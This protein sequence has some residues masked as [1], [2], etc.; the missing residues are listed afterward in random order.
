MTLETGHPKDDNPIIHVPDNEVNGLP[1]L[2]TKQD[3][4]RLLGVKESWL[5][6]E[7]QAGRIQHIRLGKKKFIRFRP[8]HIR[9]YLESKTVSEN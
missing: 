8:E 1:V 4:C 9:A 3:V 7:I 2:L 6:A 5:T